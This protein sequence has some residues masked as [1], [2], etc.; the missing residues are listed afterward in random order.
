MSFPSDIFLA[1]TAERTDGSPRQHEL[2]EHLRSVAALAARNAAPF[3]SADWASVAGLWHDLGKYREGFQRYIRSCTDAH[4]EGRVAGPEKTHSAAGALHALETLKARHGPRGQ[5][6]ATVLAYLIAGHH[7]GLA[8]WHGGLKSRLIDPKARCEYDEART[9]APQAILS[10]ATP[11]LA[12][13]TAVPGGIATPGAFALWVRMLFSALVDADFLDTEAFMRSD[14]A[15]ARGEFP[16]LS[17]MRDAY[18]AH[19]ACFAADTPVRRIRADI[20]HQCRSKAGL[21][22]GLF[23]LTV[24]A[25]GGKTLASLGFALD[26]AQAHGKRRVVYAI[27]YTSIIEQ[28]ADVFRHVFAS[29][30]RECVVEHHSQAESDPA[31]ETSASR[32]ACENWD[33]PLVVTTNVQLFESLFAARTS[34]CRKL[35]NL[36]NNVLILDEAQQLPAEFLQPILDVLR[37]LVQHYGVTVVLCTATQPALS[38]TRYFDPAMNL[39]GLDNAT[40]LMDDPDALYAALKRVNVQ[41]PADFTTPTEWPQL[42]DELAS[43]DCAL[44]IVNTRK[45]ARELFRRM[46]TG[47]LHLS[48][49]MCGAHRKDVIDDIKHQLATR[50]TG[51][52]HTPLR[53]VSTQLVE[54]G[55]DLDFPVVYRALAGLDAIAQAAGRC[56]REGQLPHPGK[57]VVFVPPDAIPAGSLRKAAD[58]CR[59]VLHNHTGDPLDRTLFEP[60]FRQYYASTDLDRCRVGDLLKPEPSRDDPLAI[61]FRSAADAFRLIND[62]Q[63]PVVVLYRGADGQDTTVDMLLGKLA[64][65]GP[66]RWLLRALQRYTVSLRQK[67]AERLLAQG[68]LALVPAVPGLYVQASDVLYDAQLGL[69]IDDQP[70]PASG[71]VC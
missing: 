70:L 69:R 26:H 35:H 3:G 53:V 20:L 37:L 31:A 10:H 45:S 41:L 4:I 63:S 14:K 29:I 34:R 61:A 13:Q 2:S 51:R 12:L 30:G 11:D 43:H 8:D 28:T 44:A 67:D 59:S 57:V 56:N 25:G 52:S 33:A 66:E 24:P 47:T 21:P 5:L 36:T 62:D 27:P 1:H 49:L 58:A 40:E 65:D 22:P 68:D 32:L 48:A 64:K 71:L 23:T 6:A 50:K 18:N 38:T 46:P 16:Q 15:G 55:V 17:E 60:Y 54:A 7:A 9:A 39:R 19:M 42:A